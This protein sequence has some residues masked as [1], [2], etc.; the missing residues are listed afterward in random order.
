MRVDLNADA[1]ES[2]GA[3]TLGSD[4][5]LFHIVTSVNLACGFHAGDPTV[6]RRALQAA[7][8]AGLAIGAH[9]SY[10]DLLGFGRRAMQLDAQAVEDLVLYQIAALAGMAA[11]EGLRIGHVK[12]HGALYNTAATDPLV[13]RAVAR[14]VRLCDPSLALIGLAGSALVAA[15]RSEGL[16]ALEEAFADRGYERDGTL[17][18]RG[19]AGAVIDT[20]ERAAAR[21]VR[22]A[23]DH[24]AETAD[25][26]EI[27][28]RADTICIHGDT[29]GAPALARAV[30]GAL[31]RAGVQ[32]I[33]PFS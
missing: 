29:P 33:A 5:E 31:E 22:I 19:A 16:R 9:P 12:P 10:P 4:D 28:V 21:A 32:V 6:I 11:A 30:R 3:W 24:R 20:P 17:T 14:A 18:P 7:G 26:G 27:E 15:A 2:F 8:R 13:A 25:G 23:R 1:G